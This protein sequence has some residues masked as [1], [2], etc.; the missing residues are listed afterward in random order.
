[1]ERIILNPL[2]KMAELYRC[3]SCKEDRPIVDKEIV[4]AKNNR[5]RVSGKCGVCSKKVSKFVPKPSHAGE[6][7]TGDSVHDSESSD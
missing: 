7:T 4:L 2:L 6:V 1:M 5:Y 3:L